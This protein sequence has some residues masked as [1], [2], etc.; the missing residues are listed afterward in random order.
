MVLGKKPLSEARLLGQ[1]QLESSVL[2]PD[3]RIGS[4]FRSIILFDALV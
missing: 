3:F 2:S 1:F 4:F